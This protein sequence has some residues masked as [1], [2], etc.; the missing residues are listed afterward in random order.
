MARLCCKYKELDN[1]CLCNSQNSLCTPNQLAYVLNNTQSQCTGWIKHD[2]MSIIYASQPAGARNLRQSI[3]IKPSFGNQASWMGSKSF[4]DTNIFYKTFISC[5]C[6]T[7]SFCF[8]IY[9]IKNNAIAR[10]RKENDPE[11]HSLIFPALG[12]SCRTMSTP[13]I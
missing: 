2:N 9:Q 11:F 12:R 8:L 10:L 7:F 1:L 13:W 3:G 5:G 6:F 4:V